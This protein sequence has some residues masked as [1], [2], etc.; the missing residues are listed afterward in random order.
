MVDSGKRLVY[1]M[2][3]GEYYHN[4]D[5]KGRAIIPAKFREE[6]GKTFILN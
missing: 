1:F 4:I 6:L 5:S 3:M 2:F